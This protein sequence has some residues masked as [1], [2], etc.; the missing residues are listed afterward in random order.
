MIH[1]ERR[2]ISALIHEHAATKLYGVEFADFV[3]AWV[4]P[5]CIKRVS[6]Y[7]RVSDIVSFALDMSV[8]Q[9]SW[10]RY[11]PGRPTWFW[12]WVKWGLRQSSR[13]ER[14]KM[15]FVESV[16]SNP[17]S[18]ASMA[19]SQEISAELDRIYRA[20]RTFPPKKQRIFDL[21]FLQDLTLEETGAIL[22]VTKQAVSL[23]VNWLREELSREAKKCSK[24]SIA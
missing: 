9:Q 5:H 7:D 10:F 12:T 3:A 24:N 21:Y 22:G 6:T 14:K 18:I 20:V 23:H 2:A 19:P 16:E 11:I 4:V 17:S 1:A 15:R 13:L 8:K